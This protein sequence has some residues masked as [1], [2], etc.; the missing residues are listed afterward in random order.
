MDNILEVRNLSVYLN[1]YVGEVKAVRDISFYIKKGETLVI[2]GES[3]CGK[4]MTAKSILKLLPRDIANI[5]SMSEI[6][7]K[8]KNILKMSEK[9]LENLRGADISMIFQDPMTYL[10]PTMTVE[11]QIGESLVIHKKMGKKERK[12]NI[13]EILRAVKISNPEERMKQYPH[14]LSGGMRQRVIIAIALAAE[15]QILIADEPTTAL[16]V[17]TQA[18]IMNLIKELQKKMNMAVI[19]VTHDLGI[20]AEVGDRIQ[21]MYA[22]EIVEEGSK[23]DIFDNPK[24]PYTWALLQSVPSLDTNLKEKLYSLKGNPPDLLILLKECS[25]SSRCEYCMNICKK[26]KPAKIEIS[27]THSSSCWLQHPMA[28]KVEMP[29]RIRRK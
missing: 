26:A 2:V 29:V 13:I 18:D 4:T 5:N 6:I 9:Q 24:H 25:F 16:D 12:E 21:V 17:T 14:E 15:P 10:N 7:F 20:A 19:L 28:P 22:G 8:G 11:E 3:G 1:T 23:E 27:D